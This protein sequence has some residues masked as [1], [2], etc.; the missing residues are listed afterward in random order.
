MVDRTL[1]AGVLGVGLGLVLIAAPAAIIR[2]HL[3]GRAPRDKGSE[4]GQGY[5]PPASWQW[6]VRAIGAAL[7]AAGLFFGWQAL[8]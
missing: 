1:L 3:V 7:V 4:Y 5:E 6:A 8:A 2:V